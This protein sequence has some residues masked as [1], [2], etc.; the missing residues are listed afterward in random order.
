MN[1]TASV[2]LSGA[3]AFDF[4]REWQTRMGETFPL[5]PLGPA[6]VTR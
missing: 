4:A 3:N 5:A 1:G 6:T 2:E